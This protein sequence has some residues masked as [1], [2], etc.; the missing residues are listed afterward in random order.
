MG[1]GGRKSPSGVQGQTPGGVWLR[2]PQKPEIT[3]EKK[4]EEID[5]NTQIHCNEMLMY[6]NT[7][8][9]KYKVQSLSSEHCS[10]FTV[11]C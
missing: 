9:S 1:F 2:S 5:A 4:T 11:I 3:V 7:F 10:G 6:F 8:T